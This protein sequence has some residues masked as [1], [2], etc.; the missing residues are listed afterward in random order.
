MFSQWPCHLRVAIVIGCKARQTIANDVAK[1]PDIDELCGQV[2]TSVASKS[3][4]HNEA[5]KGGQRSLELR[6]RRSHVRV[7]PGAP[8]TPNLLAVYGP[9]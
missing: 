1:P 9:I 6:T 2:G 4:A 5:R 3:R 8:I 7:M